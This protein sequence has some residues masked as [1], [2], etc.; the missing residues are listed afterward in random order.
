ML[1]DYLD[2]VLDTAQMQR[3]EAHLKKCPGCASERE[4][5][6]T[7]WD[8][9]ANEEPAAPS[10]RIRTHFLERLEQ[11]KRGGD[12]V[13]SMAG[14]PAA[15]RFPWT[16]LLKVAASI[17]LLASAFMLG[18]YRQEQKSNL[19]IAALRNEGLEVRQTAMLS[20]MENKSASKRIQGVH[21][22]DG[23]ADPDEAIVKALTDRMLH[24]ENTNVRLSALEALEKFTASE[25]V[26]EAFIT[27][28]KT[29]KDSGIQIAIIQLLV[30]IQEKKAVAP[31]QRLLEHEDTQPFVKE[32]I[33]SV[34]PAI[35]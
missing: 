2:G 29:E 34:L 1:P 21:Y 30:K 33:E 9:F 22:I 35:I 3:V 28:L 17:V 23:F 31:M 12:Q 24:D 19:E 11:E 27:A 15:K 20:L 14:D 32:Q 16:N 26:K 25:M 8:A 4:A 7:L 18:R 6:G 13:V 5:M 10:N